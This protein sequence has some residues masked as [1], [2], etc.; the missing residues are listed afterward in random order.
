MRIVSLAATPAEPAAPKAGPTAAPWGQRLALFALTGII[1]KAVFIFLLPTP[2]AEQWHDMIPILGFVDAC[3][4]QRHIIRQ[5]WALIIVAT[6][7]LLLFVSVLIGTQAH[8]LEGRVDW[9]EPLWWLLFLASL[10][11][12]YAVLSNALTRLLWLVPKAKTL[13]ATPRGWWLRLL[14]KSL[15]IIIFVPYVFTACNIHRFKIANAT[16]PRLAYGLDY[17][18]VKFRAAED[19]LPLSGWYIPCPPSDT[20]VLICHGIGANKGNFLT[21]A[22]FLHQAGFSVFI[23]DFRGHGDS[24]GHTISFGYNEARDVRGA[25]TYLRQR[26]EVK[27]ILACAFSMGGS[28]L[29]HAMPDLPEVEGVVVDSTF[30]DMPTLVRQQMAIMPLGFNKIMPFVIDGYTRLEL[31]FPVAAIA[32]VR[33][34]AII[35]P[36]PLLIIHGLSDTLI[37]PDQARRNFAA[38]HE[39]KTLWLVP[40]AN[41]I[42]A[43]GIDPDAYQRRVAGFL[44]GCVKKRKAT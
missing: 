15:A 19:R 21:Y 13:W 26:H 42:E 5:H 18:E 32:P 11:I 44:R 10:G 30:A 3:A 36:R 33:H 24:A 7:G 31:G 6:L 16:N 29:L 22:R 1:L 27:H 25:V 38:A 35:S 12:M 34:I 37:S 8:L 43:M 17:E 9:R 20:T 4:F 39:P 28:A 41:H 40:G 23:F 14:H 2:P